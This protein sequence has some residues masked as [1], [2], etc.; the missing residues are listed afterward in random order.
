MNPEFEDLINPEKYYY[1][2]II[3]QISIWSIYFINL[4]S[5]DDKVDYTERN[6]FNYYL[7]CRIFEPCDSCLDIRFQA[8]RFLSYSVAH[9]DFLHLLCNSVGLLCYSY[10][11]I[12]YRTSSLLF[13][14]FN[15]ILIGGLSFIFFKP[16]GVMI[17]NSGAFYGLIGA[18]YG[19]QLLNS[20][21]FTNS[22]NIFFGILNLIPLYSL[23]DYY[24]L[25]PEKKTA[26]VCH[27][28]GFITGLSTSLFILPRFQEKK[29][30]S[31]LEFL[32]ISSFISLIFY[33]GYGLMTLPHVHDPKFDDECCF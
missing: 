26:H 33:F 8:W 13:I 23:I 30:H 28:Y 31:V 24:F 10:T 6:N 11:N 19:H 5:V 14:Y 12:Y 4:F 18:S 32:G 25:E 15:S 21:I 9:T 2:I 29:Y 1:F 20:S 22:A 3:T 16:Y 7:P 27:F 17:G